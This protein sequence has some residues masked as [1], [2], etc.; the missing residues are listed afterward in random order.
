MRAFRF[1]T[2]LLLMFDGE[3][4]TTVIVCLTDFFSFLFFFTVYL[5]LFSSIGSLGSYDLKNT[6]LCSTQISVGFEYSNTG[7]IDTGKKVVVLLHIFPVIPLLMSPRHSHFLSRFP[8][9]P[10]NDSYA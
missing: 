8:L 5:K 1:L 6:R 3:F 2:C 7:S 10:V 9:P 4:E